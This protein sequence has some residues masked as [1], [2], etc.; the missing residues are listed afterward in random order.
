MKRLL[1]QYGSW[2]VVA[3]GVVAG[4]NVLPGLLFWVLLAASVACVL[5]AAGGYQLALARHHGRLHEV[6]EQRD[7]LGEILA[8]HEHHDCKV[9]TFAEAAAQYGADDWRFE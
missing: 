9:P 6:E 2:A 5:S 3:A 4:F 7:R 1:L 8:C